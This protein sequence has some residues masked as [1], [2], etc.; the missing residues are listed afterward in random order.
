MKTKD[1]T[2]SQYSGSKKENKNFKLRHLIPLYFYP[3]LL[4]SRQH[5]QDRFIITKQSKKTREIMCTTR[6]KPLPFVHLLIKNYSLFTLATVQHRQMSRYNGSRE[7]R[8]RNPPI[9][10]FRSFWPFDTG[11]GNRNRTSLLGYTWNYALQT[12]PLKAQVNREV[13]KKLLLLL[14]N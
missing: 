6:R 12:T 10:L 2:Y 14:D 1:E 8:E 11:F 7:G 5:Y 4:P 13:L 3:A 9:L